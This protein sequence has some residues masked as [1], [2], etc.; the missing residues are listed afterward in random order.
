MAQETAAHKNQSKSKTLPTAYMLTEWG[1]GATWPCD[2]YPL[3]FRAME[4]M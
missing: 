2:S 4:T 1:V 3:N